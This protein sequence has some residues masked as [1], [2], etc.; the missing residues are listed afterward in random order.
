MSK[1]L[2]HLTSGLDLLM[3][4]VMRVALALTASRQWMSWRLE[5]ASDAVAEGLAQGVRPMVD[6]WTRKALDRHQA[7]SV[8]SHREQPMAM[9]KRAPLG[10]CIV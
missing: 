4:C 10:P 9:D 6:K 1:L 3:P 8:E 2:S 5:D 7:A